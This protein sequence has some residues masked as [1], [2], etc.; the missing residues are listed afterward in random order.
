MGAV[1]RGWDW[2]STSLG[3][4]ASWSPT[5]LAVLNL[6]LNSDVPSAV[7]W[8]PEMIMIYNDRYRD[9]IAKRHPAALGASARRV[10]VDLW[11]HIGQQLDACLTDGISVIQEKVSI[12]L[13]FEGRVYETFWNF[14]VSPVYEDGRIA[15]VYKT[16]QNITEEVNAT[17]ALVTS[18]ERLRLALSAANCLGTWDWHVPSDLIFG[19][20]RLA[21]V[22]GV[23]AQELRNGVSRAHFL[24]NLLGDDKQRVLEAGERAIRTG[25]EYRME[26]RVHQ[27]DGSVRWVSSK[28]HCIYDDDGQPT[29]FCGITFDLTAEHAAA[30]ENLRHESPSIALAPTPETAGSIVSLVEFIVFGLV[31]REDEVLIKSIADSESTHIIV[32]VADEDLE[33]VVGEDGETAAG[34]RRILAAASMKRDRRYSLEIVG[35]EFGDSGPTETL[36]H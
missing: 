20:G 11:H 34:I 12:K 30:E 26:Y 35:E 24:R 32:E 23:D 22:Y 29:R 6:A 4:V 15:G 21:E 2:A 7:Y 13:P 17:N 27:A 16:C 5:L 28:G 36:I 9:N 8:G 18:D 31:S 33:R 14:S 3:P 19:E 10:W 1:I 25:E